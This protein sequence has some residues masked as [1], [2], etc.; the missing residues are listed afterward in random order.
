MIP[1]NVFGIKILCFFLKKKPGDF[2][3]NPQNC[4][5]G[6]FMRLSNL[7]LFPIIDYSHLFSRI[8]QNISSLFGI[9]IFISYVLHKCC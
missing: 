9:Q 1:V 2:T 5:G 6:F 8:F 7:S 4:F 3:Y